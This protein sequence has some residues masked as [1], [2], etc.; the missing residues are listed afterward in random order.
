MLERGEP[1]Q[2][3]ERMVVLLSLKYFQKVII[4]KSIL[5]A[6]TN[7]T[8]VLYIQVGLSLKHVARNHDMIVDGMCHPNYQPNTSRMGITASFVSS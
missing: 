8:V 1:H 4:G 2:C 3:S 7:T 6:T 5:I